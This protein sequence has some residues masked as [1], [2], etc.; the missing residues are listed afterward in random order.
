MESYTWNANA[1]QLGGAI[2]LTKTVQM[3]A[4]TWT[5]PRV[6][7]SV[8]AQSLAAALCFRADMNTGP[9][10]SV[11][12]C[13][14]Q[15]NATVLAPWTYGGG[16]TP[17]LVLPDGDIL[18]FANFYPP[19]AVTHINGRNFWGPF[20]TW[21]LEGMLRS[22]DGGESFSG[23]VNIDG[24]P[25]RRGAYG[26]SEDS[27]GGFAP[28][29]MFADSNRILTIGN[30]GPG[31]RNWESSSSDGGRSWAPVSRGSFYTT[32]AASVT[33]ASG[34][35]IAAGRAPGGVTLHASFDGGHSWPSFFYIDMTGTWCNGDMME[36]APDEVLFV[37]NGID[38]SIGKQ[39]RFQLIG[40]DRARE[41]VGPLGSEKNGTQ[42]VREGLTISLKTDD[43]TEATYRVVW[44]SPFPFQCYESA[45]MGGCHADAP[46]VNPNLTSY[47]IESN[48][49]EANYS[50]YT[51]GR[52]NGSMTSESGD[53]LT[54]WGEDL[55]L[56]P[57]R[58][59]S[60]GSGG[61]HFPQGCL[62]VFCILRSY[63]MP[64]QQNLDWNHCGKCAGTIVHGGIPQLAVL[65]LTAHIAKL[66]NDINFG[67]RNPNLP[68][69][70]RAKP[71]SPDF[72]GI[73]V[74]VRTTL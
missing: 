2:N 73:G 3:N 17:L 51:P 34:V 42:S 36:I 50:S 61:A 45:G 13:L 72:G 9:G 5:A 44:N 6:V 66:T 47:H 69:Q 70:I 43:D 40:V 35:L 63:F 24:R 4:T 19:S 62:L 58:R 21:N 25:P 56:Y 59:G 28:M 26:D 67:L 7:A 68:S 49:G 12:D 27:K 38:G 32:A 29:P 53:V 48:T 14:A 57:S 10:S 41:W 65:N 33:T 71:L 20:A 74:L 30:G 37:Y 15:V 52:G 22:T 64:V 16:G 1:I 54:L 18:L 46:K 60:F 23:P 39:N 11:A 55:G 8:T 31:A